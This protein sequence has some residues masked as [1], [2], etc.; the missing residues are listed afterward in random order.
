MS[1]LLSTETIPTELEMDFSEEVDALYDEEKPD[2]SC[3]PP[4]DE[5]E[6]VEKWKDI[7]PI[8]EI[9]VEEEDSPRGL[10]RKLPESAK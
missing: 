10:K 4:S 3:C 2:C 7:G 9:T 6:T 1:S 8:P 5:I